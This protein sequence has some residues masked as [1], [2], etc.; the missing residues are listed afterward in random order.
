MNGLNPHVMKGGKLRDSRW[1]YSGLRYVQLVVCQRQTAKHVAQ[2]LRCAQERHRTSCFP[3]P[4][5]A[6]AVVVHRSDPSLS[7]NGGFR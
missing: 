4:E 7:V 6:E 1:S 3:F 2:I 5:A